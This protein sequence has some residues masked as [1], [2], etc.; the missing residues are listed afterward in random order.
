MNSIGR[1]CN[2]CQTYGCVCN[3]KGSCK[4]YF[5]PAWYGMVC[6]HCNEK[7]AVSIVPW[8]VRWSR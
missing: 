7:R 8:K 2:K 3:R 1:W 4:H 6:I 5:L